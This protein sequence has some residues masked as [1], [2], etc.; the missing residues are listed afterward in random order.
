MNPALRYTLT[1]GL[2]AG[3]LVAVTGLAQGRAPQFAEFGRSRAPLTAAPLRSAAPGP[4]ITREAFELRWAAGGIAP[5]SPKARVNVPPSDR[6]AGETETDGASSRR[7]PVRGTGARTKVAAVA[8]PCADQAWPYIS[9]E[10]LSRAD[11]A[12]TR[13]AVRTIPI[14]LAPT[15][16]PTIIR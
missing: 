5:A 8:T 14:D 7:A 11:G 6:L 16:A 13:R 12:P 15:V 3:A 9:A 4:V 10:C 2:M 1:L